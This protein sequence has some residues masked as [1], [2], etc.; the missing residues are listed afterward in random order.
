MNPFLERRDNVSRAE[1]WKPPPHGAFKCNV[2][3][4]FH[5]E[6]NVTGM[7]MCIRDE[8]GRVVALKTYQR[9]TSC[10]AVQEGEALALA[11]AMEF[12][13]SLGFNNIDITF[14]SDFVFAKRQINGVAHELVRAAPFFPSLYTSYQVIPCIE[15]LVMNEMS[16]TL[17][18]SMSIIMILL[19]A[20]AR[21]VFSATTTSE[22]EDTHSNNPSLLLHSRRL[23]QEGENHDSAY[24]IIGII[25]AM[26]AIVLGALV[27]ACIR[28]SNS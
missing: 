18:N 1:R 28:R 6:E 24:V 19:V 3:A 14:E 5:K 13:L 26:L 23:L 15:S 2:D 10:M 16:Q 20:A 25:C 9:R 7:G 8:T 17:T 11:V 12:I 22:E 4:S 21:T 27:I